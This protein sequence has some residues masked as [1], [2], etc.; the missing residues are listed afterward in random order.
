MLSRDSPQMPQCL[1]AY[2]PPPITPPSTCFKKHYIIY[3]SKYTTT[4]LILACQSLRFTVYLFFL[5]WQSP[6]LSFVRSLYL[7]QQPRPS[8][9]FIP[10][11][12]TT[13]N[14]LTDLLPLH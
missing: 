12:I 9:L 6:P 13:T 2:L 11:T 1:L 14:V 8:Q 4:S 10:V 5:P 3:L 7:S